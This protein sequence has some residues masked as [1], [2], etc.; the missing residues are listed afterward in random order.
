[1]L[2]TKIS[3][4]YEVLVRDLHA[5]LARNDQF[6]NLNVLH[7]VKIK[8]HSGATHQIDVYWEFKVAGTTYKTCIECKH[9]NRR[10]KKSDVASFSS[11]IQDIGNVT[12]I[13]ATTLGYQQGAVLV[14]KANGIRLI[15]VNHLLKSINITSNFNA[16]QT[17]ILQI[18]YDKKQ[19]EER[20]KERNL[21][22]FSMSTKWNQGTV[23]FDSNG[24]ER[25]RLM[26]FVSESMT[27]EGLGHVEPIDLYDKTELGLL[28]IAEIQYRLTT[29]RFQIADEVVLNDSARAIMED[30]LENQACYLN[31]DGS[32]SK[33][34]I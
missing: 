29:H 3:T 30:V 18:K 9:Y 23:L 20:L 15:I 34:E 5:A 26:Q 16:P 33:I 13:F 25:I 28:R 31:D 17:D 4:D 6:Q 1:M 24:K 19:A 2:M 22:S 21:T 11:I 12:G 27:T 32:V 10:V 8:G 7:N 14:A